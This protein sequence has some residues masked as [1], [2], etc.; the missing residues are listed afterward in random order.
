MSSALQ[1]AQS[2]SSSKQW[3][4]R[5]SKSSTVSYRPSRIPSSSSSQLPTKPTSRLDEKQTMSRASQKPAT[6]KFNTL[7]SAIGFKS[8]KNSAAIDIP[9][10]PS[11]PPLPFQNPPPSSP[12]RLQTSSSSSSFY[13]GAKS[14]IEPSIYTVHSL[15]DSSEPPTP[16]DASRHRISYQPSLFTYA[17][18]EHIDL[19]RSENLAIRYVP[20]D[21]RRVSV[22]SDPSI[23]DPQMKR[24]ESGFRYSRLS[25]LSANQTSAGHNSQT[26]ANNHTRSL[27][28]NTDRRQSLS[29]YAET[30]A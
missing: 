1:S 7:V 18:Q 9:P 10:G 13:N 17:E 11:S 8:K 5:S 23:I 4:S 19:G 25:S 20:V 6:L 15:E 28:G 22:M 14:P 2:P 24:N 21:S 29:G 26:N 30:N 3:W 27:N 12:P 16:S